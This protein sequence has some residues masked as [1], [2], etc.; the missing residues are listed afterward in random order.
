MNQNINDSIKLLLEEYR[1][2]KIKKEK[3]TISSEELET[4]LKLIS[5]MDIKND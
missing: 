3:K 5:F 1:R 2:L 4:F